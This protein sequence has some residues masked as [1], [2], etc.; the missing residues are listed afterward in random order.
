MKFLDSNIFI[1]AFYRPR[2]QLTSSEKAMKDS[3]KRIV[4]SMANGKESVV[5]TVV[6]LSEVA[7]ILKHSFTVK[8]LAEMLTGLLMLDNVEVLGVGKT[9][10]FAATELGQE[11][12]LD[13][14]DA[15]AVQVMQSKGLSE[16]YSFDKVFDEIEEITRLPT[17]DMA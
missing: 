10:Y 8:Q 13:P 1:Y 7:N 14:N 2:R 12:G 9:E 16:I 17:G 15:L 3:S 6:H 11:L 4:T 5:T